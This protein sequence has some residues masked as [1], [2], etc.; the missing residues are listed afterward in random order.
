MGAMKVTGWYAL[1]GTTYV[2]S[3]TFL[4]ERLDDTVEAVL[5]TYPDYELITPITVYAQTP[6]RRSINFAIPV[7]HLL[8]I[9]IKHQ[10][11]TRNYAYGTLINDPDEGDELLFDGVCNL[12]FALEKDDERH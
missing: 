6:A 11:A 12:R 3:L 5:K 1:Q 8:H 9:G 2:G 7:G 10:G 4:I